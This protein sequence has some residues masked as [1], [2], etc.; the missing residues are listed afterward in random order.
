MASAFAKKQKTTPKQSEMLKRLKKS[1]EEMALAHPSSKMT[2]KVKKGQEAIAL[3][4]ELEAQS[5]KQAQQAGP[6]DTVFGP[7]EEAPDPEE[8][9][10]LKKIQRM[11]AILKWLNENLPDEDE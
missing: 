6:M 10:R 2:E 9:E 8:I 1:F 5:D 4:Q 7:K 11:R 3:L